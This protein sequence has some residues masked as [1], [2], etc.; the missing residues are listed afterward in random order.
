[1]MS[2]RVKFFSNANVVLQKS[3]LDFDFFPTSTSTRP[4]T[5][6]ALL[7]ILSRTNIENCCFE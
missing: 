4:P 3:K 1:M 5:D 6:T 7:S 2:H